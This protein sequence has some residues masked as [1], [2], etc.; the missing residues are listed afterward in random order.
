MNQTNL[1]TTDQYQF[2]LVF[3][4]KFFEKVIYNWIITH[5]DKIAILYDQQYGFR[6]NCSTSTVQIYLINKLAG[7]IDDYKDL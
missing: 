5:L 4:S 6:K 7:D 1:K 2:C 3:L